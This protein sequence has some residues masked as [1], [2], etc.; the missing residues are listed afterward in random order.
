MR[1]L[2]TAFVLLLSIASNTSLAQRAAPVKGPPTI[3]CGSYTEARINEMG[4]AGPNPVQYFA[5][6]QGYLSGYNNYGKAPIVEVPEYATI[7]KYLD[8]YCQDNP[9]HRVANGIDSL[10]AE[11]GGYRQPYLVK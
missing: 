10:L 4:S 3:S 8:K 2:L 7:A 11:L 5:W 9:V 1:T 6:V